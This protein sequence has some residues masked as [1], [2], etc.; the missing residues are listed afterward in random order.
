M[1]IPIK[2]FLSIK[3]ERLIRDALICNKCYK[4]I[5]GKCLTGLDYDMCDRFPM[6]LYK[7]K[8]CNN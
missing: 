2:I 4:D 5:K 6:L 8:G 7:Y 1:K 3:D